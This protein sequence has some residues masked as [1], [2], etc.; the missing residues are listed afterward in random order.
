MRGKSAAGTSGVFTPTIVAVAP[1]ESAAGTSDVF[2]PTIV[3]VAP[4]E[5]AAG[6]DGAFTPTIVA[7]ELRGS[8]VGILSGLHPKLSIE[9]FE[10]KGALKSSP[11]GLPGNWKRNINWELFLVKIEKPAP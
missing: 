3:A 6:A 11:I 5:S 1:R 7:I 4:R 2:T 8:A 9:K 10:L